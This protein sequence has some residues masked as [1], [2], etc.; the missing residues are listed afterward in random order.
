MIK[1]ILL[2][3]IFTSSL[4]AGDV[5]PTV[6]KVTFTKLE[7]KKSDSTYVTM[8]EGSQEVDIASRSG[9]GTVAGLVSGFLAPDGIYTHVKATFST[10]FTVAGCNIA[11]ICTK[12]DTFNYGSAQAQATSAAEVVLKSHASDLTMS[13]EYPLP[14]SFSVKDGICT[15]KERGLTINFD[16]TGALTYTTDIDKDGDSGTIADDAFIIGAPDVT[17]D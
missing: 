17:L 16:V 1:R 15:L 11:S 13:G 9:S 12:N 5:T 14:V 6:Y 7:L 10:S 2:L 8:W 4:I 3:A